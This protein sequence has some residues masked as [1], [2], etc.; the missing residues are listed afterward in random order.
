M[1]RKILILGIAIILLYSSTYT[2]AEDSNIEKL[3]KKVMVNDEIINFS[4]YI[5]KV[6]EINLTGDNKK[7]IFIQT[8]SDGSTPYLNYYIYDSNLKLLKHRKKL[9]NSQIKFKKTSYTVY[10]KSDKKITKKVY[11]NLKL[12]EIIEQKKYSSSAD[13]YKSPSKSEIM[14]KIKK[15][16]NKKGIP[17]E[18]L[19]GIAY[20]ES[21]FRQFNNG[22]PL[23]SFDNVSY[24]IMQIN[25]VA[26]PEYNV[27]KLKND[28]DY[29][30]N[31]GAEILL[32]K[33]GYAFLNKPI[34][35]KVNNSDPRIIEN[36]Y[37]AVWAYNGWSESNNPNMIPYHFENWTK[38][39]TYQNKVFNYIKKE[40]DNNL[41]TIDKNNLCKKGLPKL[42]TY[43]SKN[44][45]NSYIKEFNPYQIG[46]SKEKLK[47]RNYK[48]EKTDYLSPNEKVIIIKGP[49]LFNGYLRYFIS[50]LKNEE[51]K[52]WIAVNWITQSNDLENDLLETINSENKKYNLFNQKDEISR[53]KKWTIKFNDKIEKEKIIDYITIKNKLKRDEINFKIKIEKNNVILITKKSYDIDQQYIILI[54]KGLI[55]KNNKT[56]SKNIRF[57]FDT[58][59]V[60]K[61]K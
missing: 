23:I 14:K 30:I 35:P 11:E 18:I 21:R 31:A 47:I 42:K 5:Y 22:K 41:K 9:I 36:W 51:K 28:I 56:L 2:W 4:N 46:M 7:E 12:K 58:I 44:K 38:I 53:D 8:I 40:Y 37:F 43:F 59:R 54:N 34:I 15:V 52:G 19:M 17:S 39:E 24:G 27:E 50:S 16:A 45:T 26:H 29:N 1:K 3:E 20:T 48:G 25:H 60:I 33:W 61:G 32:N 57:E 13:N 6:K 55:S 49:V 10:Q